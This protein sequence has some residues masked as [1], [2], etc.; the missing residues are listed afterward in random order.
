[1]ENIILMNHNSGR[2]TLALLVALLISALSTTAIPTTAI[3][4]E[5]EIS[6]SPDVLQAVNSTYLAAKDAGMVYPL[7]ESSSHGRADL[8]GVG[9]ANA[10][11]Q[12]R[13]RDPISQII[14]AGLGVTAGVVAVNL[15]SGG[16]GTAS[17][18]YTMMGATLGFS[19][20][21]HLYRQYYAPPIP[22]VP[23]SVALRINP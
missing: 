10:P 11:K 1:M 15:L 9:D 13:T 17:R 4:A 16:M 7:E 21:D 5:Q 6:A 2:S 18:F 8:F 3:A 12:Q 20:G 22:S 19:V 23:S 14:A